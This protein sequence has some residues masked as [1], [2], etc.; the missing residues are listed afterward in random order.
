MRFTGPLLDLCAQ[1]L[2]EVCRFTHP[3]DAVL[4]RFFRNHRSAGRN[5]RTLVAET[6]YAALRR[7]FLFQAV[8]PGCDMRQLALLVWRT[9]LGAEAQLADGLVDEA[10]RQWLREAVLRAGADHGQAV[11]CDL[12]D[13]VLASLRTRFDEA[14]LLEQARALQV[15]APLDLRVNILK[16]DRET[17]LAQLRADGIAAEPTPYSPWGIRV[18]GNPALNRHPLFM[19]GAIEVQ[20]EGSQLIA[21][22]VEPRRGEM[23]VDLCAGAGGKTLP[24]GALMRS[25][26]RLYAFDVSEHRLA[27]IKPRLARSGLQNVHVQ[28]IP[29][30]SDSRITRL[31]GKIH[32]VLVDAPCSGLGTLRRNP[33]LKIRQTAAGVDG[34]VRKQLD[35]LRRA[36]S[37]PLAGGRLVYATC[38]LLAEENQGVVATF[39]AAHPEYRLLPVGDIL[40]RHGIDLPMPGDF[41]EMWPA[42]H[43][44]DAFFAAVMQR[45]TK[46]GEGA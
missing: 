29:E 18:Q 32:R 27:K 9:R 11:E 1:A 22:L 37:L 43:G 7:W 10:Q 30:Q 21:L 8:A 15:A 36:A 5:D 2:T 44:T 6:V 46:S 12:P 23:V 14:Q 16:A 4:S 40:A 31:A 13:W 42:R 38:S 20:D 25:T 24:L 17:V 41:L 45:G 3:A 26:G 34:L 39:L 33:D 35:I 19:A 28:R